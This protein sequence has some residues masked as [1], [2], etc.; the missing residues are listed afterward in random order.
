MD[1]DSQVVGEARVGVDDDDPEPFLHQEA[2]V[3]LGHGIFGLGDG[4]NFLSN[5]P[6]RNFHRFGLGST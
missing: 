1:V 6:G 2:V 4:N 3:A 5:L